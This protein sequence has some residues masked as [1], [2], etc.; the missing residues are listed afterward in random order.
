MLVRLFKG[1]LGTGARNEVHATDQLEDREGLSASDWRKRG[2]AFLAEARLDDAERCY[3]A[4]IQAEPN[5]P[6]CYSTLGYVL[7]EKKQ[8]DDAHASLSR[9]VELNPA[10]QDSYYLLAN[11]NRDRGDWRVAVGLYRKALLLNPDFAQCRQDLCIALAQTGDPQQ[12]QLVLKQGPAFGEDTVNFHFFTGVLHL[13]TRNFAAAVGS[14]SLARALKPHDILIL[15]NLGTAQICTGDYFG[16]IQSSEEALAVDKDNAQAYANL[17]GA[18]RMTNQRSL[19]VENYRKSLRSNPH[20]LYVHQ[21]LLYYL[22]DSPDCTRA[23]Y[24]AEAKRYGR[25]ATPR[26]KPFTHWLCP[27]PS[28]S[29]RPLRV[30]FL[31]AD[32]CHHPVGMFLLGVLSQLD[33]TRVTCVAY[34]N[35]ALEDFFSERLKKLF[36]EWNPVIALTDQELAE[37][38]HGDRIDILLDL[39]GHTGQTRLPVFAWKPAPVQ[40]TWLGYWASTGVDEIDYILVDKV[41]VRD[42]DAQHYSETPWFL[43]DTRLCFA[44]PITAWPVEVSALPA[45][46]KGFITFGSY[47]QL[48]KVNADTLRL[49]SAVLAALPSARLRLHGLALAHEQIIFDLR[50]RLQEA[51][52]ALARVDLLGKAPYEPYLESYSDVDIILDTFPYPGGT[53]TAEAL[54]MGVPTLTMAGDTLLARQGEGMLTCVGLEDWISFG[55]AQ[56]VQKAIDKSFDLKALSDLRAGLRARALA[57][58]LFDGAR[59]AHNLENAFE[60][61]AR[62]AKHRTQWHL[63][64]Q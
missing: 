39:S 25:K 60:G 15:I 53:T 21:N 55:E 19:A 29:Q 36:Q 62:A 41:G 42:G 10:D 48:N 43:P 44:P 30:G 64:G 18:Y 56:F 38:I 3:R 46:R 58:P 35:L 20:N 45:L 59:F 31:S 12:A 1:L 52:I 57:S 49:W 51:G 5:D 37:K 6:H 23:E 50:Q 54:W 32:L 9:A 11:L 4:G 61:M 22:T 24:L 2:N 14:F 8:W 27:H 63:P 16:S 28:A 47:Q 26:A 17:A 13:Q 40:V 7:L 34:S 33:P